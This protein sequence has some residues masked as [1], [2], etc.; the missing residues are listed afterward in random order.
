[1]AF[2]REKNGNRVF[3]KDAMHFTNL[4]IPREYLN[5]WLAASAKVGVSRSEFMRQAIKEKAIATLAQ[6]ETPAE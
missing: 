4:R 1:M 6:G 5:L 2:K 3:T